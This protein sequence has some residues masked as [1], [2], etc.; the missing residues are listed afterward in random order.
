VPEPPGKSLVPVFARDGTVR[1]DSLW[2][3]HEG[4]R[5]LRVGDWKVV[6][7]GKAGPWELYDLSS[8]RSET[9]DLA[10]ARPEKARELSALWARQFEEYAALARKDLPPGSTPRPRQ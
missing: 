7:A 9:R 4:N 5:A 1:R 10:A 2:W 8:D 3:L 6:A